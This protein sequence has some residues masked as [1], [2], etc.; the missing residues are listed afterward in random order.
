MIRT[1]PGI[2]LAM[3]ISLTLGA[4]GSSAGDAGQVKS[5][6]GLAV[7]PVTMTQDGKQHVFSAEVAATPAQQEQGLMYRKALAPDAAMLFPFPQPKFASFWMKNTLIPLDIVFIRRNGTIDKIAENTVPMSEIPIAS[8]GEVAAVLEL[9]GGTAERLG[10]DD[11][12]TVRWTV[13]AP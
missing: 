12:A 2:A 8:G 7:I 5:E 1:R 4:C 6:A 9:A 11:T 10:L 13:P 3:A